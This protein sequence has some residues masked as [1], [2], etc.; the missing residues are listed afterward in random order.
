MI[1]GAAG[2]GCLLAGRSGQGRI[3]G[4]LAGA[5]AALL[6][7]LMIDGPL[8][9][10]PWWVPHDTAPLDAAG[11]ARLVDPIGIW[12]LG[13]LLAAALAVAVRSPARSR[14]PTGVLIG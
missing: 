1:V 10:L 11:F 4:L 14:T 3:A 13:A 2:T 6:I 8:P 12:A 9:A 7:G 5:S